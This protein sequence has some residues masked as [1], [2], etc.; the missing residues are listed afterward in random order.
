MKRI[1]FKLTSKKHYDTY[2]EILGPEDTFKNDNYTI[3]IFKYIEQTQKIKL[4]EKVDGIEEYMVEN[5]R[6]VCGDKNF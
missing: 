1:F 2:M 3:K 6:Q 5:N 4:V